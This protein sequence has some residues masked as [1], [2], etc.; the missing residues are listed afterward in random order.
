MNTQTYNILIIGAPNTGKSVWLKKLKDGIFV[1]EHVPTPILLS[2]ISSP[3]MLKFNTTKGEFIFNIR[4]LTFC[5]VSDIFSCEIVITTSD[6]VIK[7]CSLIDDKSL[8]ILEFINEQ[9]YSNVLVNVASKLD[10]WELG[11]DGHVKEFDGIPISSYSNSNI[12]RPFLKI[13][14]LL[15]HEDV[16]FTSEPLKEAPSPSPSLNVLSL[17]EN[18]ATEAMNTPLSDD[19]S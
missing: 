15:G 12:A 4:E 10:L 5:K 3:T 16:E 13:L 18:E 17:W 11:K 9:N 14:E 7:M 19:V 6:A 8:N 2:L 1:K